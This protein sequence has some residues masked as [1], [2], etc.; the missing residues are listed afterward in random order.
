MIT[1]PIANLLT[2][3]RNANMARKDEVQVPFSNLKIGILKVLKEKKFILDYK[4]VENGKFK[5]IAITLNPEKA[6]FDL[7][8]ISKPGQRIYSGSETIKKVKG[9]LGVTV[10]STSKGIMSG[11][12]AK[13]MH[14]G[15]EVLCQ[16][17]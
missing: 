6:K 9:G 3:I 5:D 13:K 7:K 8:R 16:I 2:S 12:E 10:I 15:G 17:F 11:E 1:D 4:L 14:I